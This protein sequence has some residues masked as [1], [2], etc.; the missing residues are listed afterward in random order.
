M[1]FRPPGSKR[2]TYTDGLFEFYSEILK[3][4]QNWKIRD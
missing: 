2:V 4:K 3:N 1:D